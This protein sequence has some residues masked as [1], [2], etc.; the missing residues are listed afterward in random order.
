MQYICILSLVNYLIYS[1][2]E[3]MVLRKI[4]IAM[5]LLLV[6]TIGANPLIVPQSA[7]AAVT[8]I[9]VDINVSGGLDNGSSWSNAFNTL[10]DGVNNATSGDEIWV[11][12]GTY[13]PS[14]W[15]N[16][17]NYTAPREMHFSMKNGVGIYGGFDGTETQRDERDWENNTT[18]LSGDIGTVGDTSDN[19]YHVFYHPNSTNLDSSAILDGFT[20]TAGNADGVSISFRNGAGMYMYN[21]PLSPPTI[22]N[23]SFSGNS[24]NLTGGGIYCRYSTLTLT[25]CSFSGN[26]ANSGVG[27]YCPYSTLTLTN[28][29]FSGNSANNDGGG[30]N[31]Q[32][33]TLTLTNCSFSG[34]SATDNGGGIYN[35]AYSDEEFPVT[36]NC[37]LTN[38]SFSGNSAS[39]N[40]GG[41][42]NYAYSEDGDS[43]TLNCMLTNCSFA[44]NSADDDGG[45][46]KNYAE[47]DPNPP[48][49]NCTMWNCI[50]WG[51]YADDAGNEIYSYSDGAEAN[52]TSYY[53][54]IEGSGGSGAGWDS[55]LGTDGG[56]NI[57]VDPVFAAEPD[58]ASAPTTNGNLHLQAGSPCIDMGNNIAVAEVS[59]D[60]EGDP[61]II[62]GDGDGT[63]IVDIGADEF[64]EEARPVGGE[65]QPINASIVLAPLLGLLAVTI[66]GST[67]ALRRRRYHS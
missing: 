58:P 41:I 4:L 34:N 9:Y 17:S 42:E 38:C 25:N 47:A 7:S 56:N 20:I 43:V 48:T 46:I 14:A 60:F 63:A 27:I 3:D 16:T 30:I 66:A 39:D 52:V 37:T 36:L 23:C 40:G 13:K 12:Q 22:N 44:G 6:L 32:D 28:C 21:Y 8:T 19:C 65:A 50:L 11:A 24:A 49:L 51:D 64:M 35:Y 59:T 53:C 10:Q 2:K 26:S 18:T 54:D 57:D 29:S 55:S 33:S 67:I 15:P 45:G 31:C 1:I 62:D 61:R 5:T